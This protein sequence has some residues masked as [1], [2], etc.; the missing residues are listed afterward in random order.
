MSK[1]KC[2]MNLLRKILIDNTSACP[3]MPK[4]CAREV[5]LWE[6]GVDV[7]IRKGYILI[8]KYKDRVEVVKFYKL[9]KSFHDKRTNN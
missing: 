9:K 1:K 8:M 4:Q 6:K 3:S 7:H 5:N 2:D